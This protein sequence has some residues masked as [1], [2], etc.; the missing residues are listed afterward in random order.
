MLCF[1]FLFY[2][3]K[4]DINLTMSQIYLGYYKS[5]GSPLKIFCF[6]STPILTYLLTSLLRVGK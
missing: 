3:L 5:R 4:S 2:S 6:F 1:E